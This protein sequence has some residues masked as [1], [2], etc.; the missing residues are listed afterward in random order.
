MKR[1]L[2]K[3]IFWLLRKVDNKLYYDICECIDDAKIYNQEIIKFKERNNEYN[4]IKFDK[5][6]NMMR[7]AKIEEIKRI[8]FYGK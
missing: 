2:V 4:A 5:T 8:I 6:F 7:I 3:I 1:K